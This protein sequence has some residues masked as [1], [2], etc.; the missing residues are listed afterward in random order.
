MQDDEGHAE[1]RSCN[2]AGR[3]APAIGDGGSG[4]EGPLPGEDED[5]AAPP[6]A[7][8]ADDP[9]RVVGRAPCEGPRSGDREQGFGIT[10]MTVISYNCIPS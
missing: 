6:E 8:V 10:D 7:Q 3:R 9:E 5:G 4:D 1:S 2:P